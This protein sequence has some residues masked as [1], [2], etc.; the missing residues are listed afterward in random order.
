MKSAFIKNAID[1]DVLPELTEGDL[2]KLG[3]PLGDRK[4]LIKAIKAVAGGS[5]SALITSEV[6]ENAPSDVAERRHLTVMFCDL[7]GSAALSDRLDPEDMWRATGSYRV[8]MGEIIDRHHGMIGR[9]ISHGVLAYFGYPQAHED[10]AERAVRAG[11]DLIARLAQLKAPVVL[12]VRV[13][14]A[15]GLV[16][17]GDLVGSGE[18]QERGIVG[19]TPNLAARLQSIAAPNMVVLA[20]DTRRLVGNLFELQDLGT[21]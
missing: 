9:D 10:D 3:I 4:R 20:D 21:S 7:V 16:V 13:G 18:A 8:C 11:L 19:E 2:E 15:T 14:I 5:P 1:T 17:V 12:Q 6:G